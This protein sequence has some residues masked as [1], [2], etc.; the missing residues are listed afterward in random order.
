MLRN[1]IILNP[2]IVFIFVVGL[3]AGF[4]LQADTAYAR[5]SLSDLQAQIDDLQTQI[6]DIESMGC[7]CPITQEEFNEVLN[8]L[9]AIECH[10]HDGDGFGAGEL[11][12]GDLDCDDG[13]DNVY[14]GS[15]EICDGKDND[16][17]G[18]V[19]GSEEETRYADTDGDGF[20][21][22]A[23]SMNVCVAPPHY[24]ADSTDCN[25]LDPA[26]YPG[27]YDIPGDGIDNDCI[28]GDAQPP[29]ICVV[30]E[31][32]SQD[33]TTCLTCDTTS[34]LA[35][36]PLVWW[37]FGDILGSIAVD[38]MGV[39]DMTYTNAPRVNNAIS[40]DSDGS[41][42]LDGTGSIA[43]NPFAAFPGTALSIE[44][45]TR[46][47]VPGRSL[48]SY[49]TAASDNEVLLMDGSQISVSIHGN[50]VDT[51]I[52]ITD[53]MWHHIALTWESATGALKVYLDGESAY[54]GNLSTGDT[55]MSNGSLYIGQEQDNVGGGLDPNQAW[56][57]QVDELAIFDRVL[58][59]NEV[60]DHYL[61]LTCGEVCDGID[62]D[63]D[64]L[65]D[66]HLLGTGPGC[67]AT[68]CQEVLQFGSSFGDGQ[69]WINTPLGGGPIELE[70]D[71]STSGGGWTVLHHNQEGNNVAP[72][73]EPPGCW[74]IDLTYDQP[75]AVVLEMLNNATEARQYLNKN[76]LNSLISYTTW[77]T[78]WT[79]V[80]GVAIDPANWPSAPD[81][82][83]INDSVW[84][85]D[86]GDITNP[87]YLPIGTIFHGDTGNS[88]EQA[89]YDLGPLRLR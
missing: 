49:A 34:M 89:N 65:V 35:S 77:W 54:S 17:A 62:N 40:H 14:P 45:W 6:N 79:T 4:G 20:G 24:V 18:G 33:R 15:T 88:A 23:Q 27:A 59:P 74:Q 60:A 3:S 5:I 13:D 58:A 30:G 63:D 29:P 86:G 43:V 26:V 21:N 55:I 47:T 12:R 46:T 78:W 31:V 1:W 11:C 80:D 71:M 9:D 66:E 7:D 53:G 44:F 50:S 61:S 38:E 10:D 16:C 87:E 75:D 2:T 51:G 57:G 22:A 39:L 36:A 69:Y 48:F 82:C 41:V 72:Q 70:C 42:L 67:A 83:N 8:R 37:R 52:D 76:C 68:N 85:S 32:L 73:C 64:G 56:V 84:R 25:D 19:P 28:G 81:Q